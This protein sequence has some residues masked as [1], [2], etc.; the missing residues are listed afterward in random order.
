MTVGQINISCSELDCD[1][2]N[3]KAIYSLN[4]YPK[5]KNTLN[6]FVRVVIR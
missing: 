2:G 5:L 4:I 6:Y 1:V 3:I